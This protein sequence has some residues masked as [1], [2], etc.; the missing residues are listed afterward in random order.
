[1]LFYSF[2]LSVKAVCVLVFQHS[3]KIQIA[4]SLTIY[5]GQLCP[6]H[7]STLFFFDA[8]L[9]VFQQFVLPLA[10]S[11]LLKAVLQHA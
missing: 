5:A 10:A 4:S 11:I 8:F 3:F 7:R 9:L 1:M 2:L 6:L